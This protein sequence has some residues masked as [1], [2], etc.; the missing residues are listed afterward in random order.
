[1]VMKTDFTEVGLRASF[2]LRLQP[3]LDQLADHFIST[4]G[5]RAGSV[6]E[7]LNSRQRCGARAIVEAPRKGMDF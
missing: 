5:V 2:A 7:I 6:P 3:K 1:M 4:M